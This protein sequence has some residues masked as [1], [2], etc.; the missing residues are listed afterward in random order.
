MTLRTS[1][2]MQVSM[3]SPMTKALTASLCIAFYGC[4]SVLSGPAED[5]SGD[6]DFEISSVAAMDAG[7]DQDMD[8]SYSR[9]SFQYMTTGVDPFASLV[10]SDDSLRP[11]IE[12]MAV[13]AIVVDSDPRLSVVLLRDQTKSLQTGYEIHRLHI[14][15]RLGNF[16][17]TAIQGDGISVETR[18]NGRV[19]SLLIPNPS[20]LSGA[21]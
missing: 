19:K 3:S 11:R 8:L 20:G 12:D 17:V 16:Q 15:D 2:R 10:I 5:M 4:G 14:G 1:P 9:E 21:F 7:M 18:I 6:S 13:V